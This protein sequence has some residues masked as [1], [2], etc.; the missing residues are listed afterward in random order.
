[1]LFR[2]TKSAKFNNKEHSTE[3]LAGLN[4]SVKGTLFTWDAT[5]SIDNKNKTNNL[6]VNVRAPF[7]FKWVK[8]APAAGLGFND[9]G[10]AT[11]AALKNAKRYSTVGVGIGYYSVNTVVAVEVYQ[12]REKFTSGNTVSGFSLGVR[13][14]M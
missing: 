1:M 7:G 6:E 5:A 10:A 11:I 3:L 14:K 4:G 2:S 12:N 8:I 9:P 13:H